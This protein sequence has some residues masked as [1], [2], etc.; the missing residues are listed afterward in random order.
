MLAKLVHATSG[1][2]P[3]MCGSPLSMYREG[4]Y[5]AANF[6]DQGPGS[7]GDLSFTV[8]LLNITIIPPAVSCS[9]AS[10]PSQ[11]HH[12]GQ[13]RKHFFCSEVLPWFPDQAIL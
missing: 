1:P 6:G 8:T 11:H 3:D 4:D 10:Q 2:L 12:A 13:H 9:P 5:F 7:F